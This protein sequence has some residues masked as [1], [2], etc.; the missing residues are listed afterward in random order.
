MDLEVLSP[1]GVELD[2]EA[3]VVLLLLL[4]S[5]IFFFRSSFFTFRRLLLLRLRAQFHSELL[6]LHTVFVKLRHKLRDLLV[7]EHAP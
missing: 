4:G 5:V 1:Q 2:V 3:L 6:H 7:F